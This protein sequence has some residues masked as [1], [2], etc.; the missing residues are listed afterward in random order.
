MAVGERGGPA[1]AGLAVL[2]LPALLVATGSAATDQVTPQ[3]AED[4]RLDDAGLSWFGETYTLLSVAFL[5]AMGA[6]A[7]RVGRRR[8]LRY[9]AAGFGLAAPLAAFSTGAATLIAAHAV[10]G[11]AAAALIPATL[12]LVRNMFPDRGRRLTAIAVL[13]ASGYAGAEAAPAL[14]LIVAEHF[15]WPWVFLCQAPI[16]LLLLALSP[17]LPESRDPGAER[18]DA[19]GAALSVVA[20]AALLYGLSALAYEEVAVVP[21]VAVAAGLALCAVVVL[22]R[23]GPAAVPLL[24]SRPPVAGFVTVLLVAAMSLGTATLGADLARWSVALDP[25]LE[26]WTLLLPAAAM[27]AGHLL[28][29]VFARRAHSASVVGGGLAV[30]AAGV[31][32]L[33]LIGSEI[34]AIPVIVTTMVL[35]FGAGLALVPA[36]ELIVGAAPPERAGVPAALPEL[37]R[38]FGAVLGF[39][40]FE[41]VRSVAYRVLL[42]PPPGLPPE[43]ADAIRDRYA[44]ESLGELPERSLKAA[45]DATTAADTASLRVSAA[46]AAIAA[47]AVAVPALMS[48]RRRTTYEETPDRREAPA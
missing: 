29:P 44:L 21:A 11:L 38:Q 47:L 26:R 12:A 13:I 34:G 37:A 17:L 31:A 7:D 22:R 4:L 6:V 2:V 33:A 48:S 28:A 27:V 15:G 46:V 40:A 5:I 42:T 10:L 24:G 3:I 30:I 16:A 18:F 9:G 45:L 14:G 19:A 25:G 23:G 36:I 32:P 39:A 1:W 35:S 8:L 43:I 20:V 41:G